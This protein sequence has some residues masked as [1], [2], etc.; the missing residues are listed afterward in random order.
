MSKETESISQ[1]LPTNKSQNWITS[2]VNSTKYLK[3]ELTLFT[4]KLFKNFE[5]ATLL[6]LFYEAHI[7]IPDT[8]ARQRQ[9]KRT[10]ANIPKRY[11]CKT[12]KKT[13]ASQIQQHIK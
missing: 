1:D 4:V 10:T 3:E 5:K 6:N 11:K 7:I 8:K 13:L 2:L 12:F 9:H